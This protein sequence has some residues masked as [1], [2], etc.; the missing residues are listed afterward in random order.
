M[1]TS[2]DHVNVNS[3]K[4]PCTIKALACP[5]SMAMLFP[6]QTLRMIS[7]F[8]ICGM[9]AAAEQALEVG[10]KLQTQGS[11]TWGNINVIS[12]HRV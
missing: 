12:V 11:L 1:V 9:V 10:P 2:E 8:V 4:T 3:P 6:Q 7:L 5:S